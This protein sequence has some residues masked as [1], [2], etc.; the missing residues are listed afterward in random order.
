MNI[1]KL[2]VLSQ[3][4]WIKTL[5]INFKLL[6]F[7][8]AR[9]LP[10]LVYGKC[11]VEIGDRGQIQLKSRAM[12]GSIFIGNNDSYAWGKKKS[13]YN[14][15]YFSINGNV[16]FNGTY[17]FIGNGCKVYVAENACLTM[18][19]NVYFNC[20][21]K[22]ICSNSIT[23]GE[24][25]RFSWECQVMDTNF[26]FIVDTEGKT[27]RRSGQIVIG[28]NC[29]IGNRVTIQKGCV[30]SDYSIVASN[31]LV[32]KDFSTIHNGTFAGT[33]AKFI[34]SGLNRLLNFALEYALDEYFDKNPDI[35]EVKVDKEESKKY[36]STKN[37]T[38]TPIEK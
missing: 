21:N 16:V 3:T 31:S 1:H 34:K 8:Q 30:L 19:N 13:Q 18:G 6:P 37:M 25:T 22:I 23:I 28:K 26:H 27:K 36:W 2:K 17:H 32:N 4:N 14:K 29:W 12:F 11:D 20:D 15:T 7:S 38:I 10:I 9:H 35:D 24:N 33:P 5:Y